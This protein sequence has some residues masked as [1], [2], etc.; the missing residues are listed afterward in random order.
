MNFIKK[1]I[2]KYLNSKGLEVTKKQADL[3]DIEKYEKE[4]SLLFPIVKSNTMLSDTR[5]LS[6]YENVEYC[7]KNNIEG[8]FVECGTWKGGAVGLMALSNMKLSNNRR[9]L[10]L[11][12]AFT[13]ICYPDESVDGER[14]I[15]EVRK[16]V[17]TEELSGQLKPVTGGYDFKGGPGTLEEN[18]LLL[19]QRI[20]YPKEYIHYH[21]GWFQDTL[22]ADIENIQAIALLR[23]D[24]DYYASTKVCLEYLFPKVVNG[25]LVVIDDYGAYDGCKKAVDE[26]IENNRIKACFA[27]IDHDARFFV[28]VD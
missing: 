9:H 3:A 10:H 6:L 21:K 8:C 25:G 5:L 27:K 19:E 14:A 15:R 18:K 11:F 22:P 7:E 17:K 23:L 1:S 26:Y 13:E 20:A 12:D 4:A 28:K 16:Y 24:G 2:L